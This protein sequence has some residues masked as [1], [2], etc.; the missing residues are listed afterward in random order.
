M[1]G[2]LI[3]NCILGGETLSSASVSS[4]E[5]G[6]GIS[7]DAGIVIISIISLFV[8]SSTRLLLQLLI[9]R[10]HRYRFVGIACLIGKWRVLS[11]LSEEVC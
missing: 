6:G 8:S 2:F 1:M 10:V 11:L 9:H 4:A 5:S 3:L 7:W